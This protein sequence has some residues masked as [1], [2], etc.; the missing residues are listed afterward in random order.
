[1]SGKRES[2]QEREKVVRKEKV[3]RDPYL[4]TSI[5]VAVDPPVVDAEERLK[6][7]RRV[8]V[9]SVESPLRSH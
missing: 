8:A 4:S 2:C 5:K 9:V 6:S 7:R 1:M 3:I